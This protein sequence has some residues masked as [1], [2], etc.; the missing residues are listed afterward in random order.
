[1][2]PAKLRR[3]GVKNLPRKSTGQLP[4][5][6]L[7]IRPRAGSLHRHG[8]LYRP[9]LGVPNEG[10]GNND[11]APARWTVFFL[12]LTFASWLM[13]TLE[14]VWYYDKLHRDDRDR[15]R[16]TVVMSVL[17]VLF[18]EAVYF[19]LGFAAL[20]VAAFCLT[21]ETCS[22]ARGRER[23]TWGKYSKEV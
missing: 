7:A 15:A 4:P 18:S 2:T 9:V 8:P 13:G 17:A 21:V 6:G 1:M 22:G 12:V 14:L 16:D 11:R 5:Y 3:N 10:Q 23:H 20:C 19:V